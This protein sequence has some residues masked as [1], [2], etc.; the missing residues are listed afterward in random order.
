MNRHFLKISG[1]SLMVVLLNGCIKTATLAFQTID[2]SDSHPLQDVR[3]V[4]HSGNRNFWRNQPPLSASYTITAP[5]GTISIMDFRD[6]YVHNLDFTKRGYK[7]SYV[8]VLGIRKAYIHSPVLGD[9]QTPTS[10][11]SANGVIIVPLHPDDSRN[12]VTGKTSETRRGAE[13]Q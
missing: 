4:R 3:I 8:S 5:N 7:A 6:D 1:F 10:I 12:G 13:V 2:A 9:G 11:V